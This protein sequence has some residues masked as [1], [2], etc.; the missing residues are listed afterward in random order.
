[1]SLKADMNQHVNLFTPGAK[2]IW[3]YEARGGYGYIIPVPAIFD[4]LTPKGCA[5]IRAKIKDGSYKKVTCDPRNLSL[6]VTEA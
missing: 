4:G 5:R 3:N 2:V 6:K 1:M